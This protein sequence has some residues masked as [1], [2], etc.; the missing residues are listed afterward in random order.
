MNVTDEV[1][2][3][4]APG[5]LL[6]ALF[7]LSGFSALVYQVAWQRILGLFSG[8][9]VRSVTIVVSAY[10]AGLGFG[11]LLGAFYADRLDSRRA[12]KVYAICNLGIATFACLSRFL[13]YD[14]LFLRLNTLARSPAIVLV[15]VFVSLLWPT[16]LMGLSLPL[17]SRAAVRS[18]EG[19]ARRIGTLNGVN[20]IAAGT[21]S[22]VGGFILIGNLGFDGAVYVGAALSALVGLLALVVAPRFSPQRPSLPEPVPASLQHPL[23]RIPRA[24]WTW[25]L[26]V[27]ISGFIAISLEIL[28]FRLLSVAQL[29]H[30]YTFSALLFVYLAGD[31]A[32]SLLG[33]RAVE[34]SRD[35][36]RDFMWIQATIALYSLLSI[37]ALSLL[38]RR[39][40]VSWL[41]SPLPL[42]II[43]PSAVLIGLGFPFVQKAVQTDVEAV[44]QRVSLIQTAN[45]VGNTAAGL[46]TGLVLLQFFGTPG[47]LRLVGLMGLLFV[48]L[49]LWEGFRASRPAARAV[50]LAMAAASL[51]TLILFPG[52]RVL[53]AHLYQADPE[54]FFA[55]AEDSSGVAILKP[56]SDNTGMYVHGVIQGVH[57]FGPV[58]TVYGLLPALVHPEAEN[59]MVIGLGLGTTA[60]SVGVNPGTE[61]IVVV[62]IVGAELPLLDEFALTDAGQ[63]V[64]ALLSDPRYEFVIGDGRRELSTSA[65]EFDIIMAGSIH[66]WSSGSGMLNSREFFEQSRDKLTGDGI[67]VQWRPTDR[68]EATF[69]QVFPYVVRPNDFLL[70]GSERPIAYD[71][72]LILGRLE[73]PQVAAYFEAANA[74]LNS[75]RE[76]IAGGP[77]QSWTPESPRT[78]LNINTDLL[79]RDEYFLNN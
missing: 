5:R 59:V 44:G 52:A 29:S 79:P 50:G 34:R 67:M 65:E 66:P 62:E 11:S 48:L 56:V 64:H 12:V 1:R 10:L 4:A 30:A 35:P 36:R 27:F 58:Q 8:S 14:L 24:V 75:V 73:D 37:W 45:I 43:L 31:G 55:Y 23:R 21:G 76:Y 26:L 77:V 3:R 13:F 18:V 41:A 74:D 63:S 51:A 32:G 6:Y 22:L 70:I 39:G 72:D 20:I 7:F 33:A 69:L 2:T 42:F 71:A 49:L 54:G 28:W 17:L 78:D 53:W 25:C 47:S 68:I 16:T 15:I 38:W 57:P 9:D 19:A 46:L 61:R 40:D 60:Y